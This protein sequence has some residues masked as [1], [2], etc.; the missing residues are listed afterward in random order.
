MQRG[1]RF[2]LQ[3]LFLLLTYSLLWL[4]LWVISFYLSHNGQQAALFYLKAYGWHYLFYFGDVFGCRCYW[5]NGG[6]ITG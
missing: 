1:A 2:F 3:S 5:P 6:F 4:S